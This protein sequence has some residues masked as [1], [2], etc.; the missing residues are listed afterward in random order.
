MEIY[1]A[2]E[3]PIVGITGEALCKKISNNVQLISDPTNLPEIVAPMLQ[4]Q[5]ILLTLGAGNIGTVAA[6]LVGK[7]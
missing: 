3:A 6:T 1:S 2:G 5:D 7:L 4:D